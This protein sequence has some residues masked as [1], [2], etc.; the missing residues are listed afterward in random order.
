MASSF[1]FEDGRKFVTQQWDESI[2]PALQDYIK[3]PNQS[4]LYDPT[5]ATNGLIDQAVDLMVQW[6]RDRQVPGLILE[7]VKHEGRTP[8]IFIEVEATTDNKE[9]T[10]L[11]YGHLDK[12]P[13]MHG[14]EEGLGPHTP[15]IRDG[16]LYGRGGA[17][18]GY[19]IFAAITAIEALKKQGVPHSRCVVIIEACEESGSRDLPYYIQLLLPRIKSPSLIICLD[20]GC[21]NYDQLWLTTSLRGAVMGNLKAE[22]LTEGVH[23]GSASGVVAS[24]FR[25]L[26]QVLDKLEDVQ[27]GKILPPFLS[28]EI[29]AFRIEQTKRAAEVLGDTIYTEFPWTSGAK[30]MAEDLTELFLNKTWRPAL[31][32]TGAEGLPS[33]ESAGNV[34]R[35]YTTLKVSLRLP[36]TINADKASQQLKEFF[37]ENAPY[38]AKVTFEAEKA[39]TGWESPKLVDWLAESVDKASNAYFGKGVCYMGEGGSIPFMGMLGE[40][41]PKAQFM[42][43]GVLGPKSNAHGPNE[44]LHIEMGKGVT[45]CVASLIADQAQHQV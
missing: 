27:T 39:G 16:K 7:V 10:I 24:S 37:E 33:L 18:D 40:L 34:L 13:P 25:I 2:V 42:I 12:Q 4:P 44:F 35:P 32:I 23:S 1:S 41:F 8:I 19:A 38:G 5:W 30:P 6:V 36:P 29:P 26:R 20:S 28:A 21:G 45:S 43:T 15:V 31:S 11:L 22:I 17:D 9:D 14:W 3:I